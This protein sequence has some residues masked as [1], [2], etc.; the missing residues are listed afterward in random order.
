MEVQPWSEYVAV[1]SGMQIEESLWFGIEIFSLTC[2]LICF[3]SKEGEDEIK[4]FQYVLLFLALYYHKCLCEELAWVKITKVSR[5][6]RS[7]TTFGS[8]ICSI[9]KC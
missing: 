2:F 8:N 5:T 1:C 7:R 6:G 9:L 3:D 4:H